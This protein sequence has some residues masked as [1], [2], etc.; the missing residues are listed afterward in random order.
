MTD[1]FD[2]AQTLLEDIK[3]EALNLSDRR[4]GASAVRELLL[5][6]GGFVLFL[7]L[8]CLLPFFSMSYVMFFSDTSS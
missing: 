2:T 3:S 7:G 8:L 6:R 1:S 4:A 5:L